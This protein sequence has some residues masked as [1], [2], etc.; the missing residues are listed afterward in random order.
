M[1][2][3]IT[4]IPQMPNIY[5]QSNQSLS[6]TESE[7]EN[8]APA[9]PTD[10]DDSIVLSDLVRTGE[11]SRLRRRGALRLDHGHTNQTTQQRSF[12]P[13]VI[14]VG[15]PSWDSESEDTQAGQGLSR[16]P[17][18]T[19]TRSQRSRRVGEEETKFSL[20]CGGEVS[21]LDEDFDDRPCTPFVPSPLPA[22]PASSSLTSRPYRKKKR[23]NGCGALLHMNATPRL[24]QGLWSAK[25]EASSAVI[26]MEPYYF[27]KESVAK[28]VRSACGCVR[29]GVGCTVW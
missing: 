13:S 14:V 10:A 6:D 19:R 28:I 22:Y 5:G 25:G 18:Y 4:V 27:D 1:R 8:I 21:D 16:V 11:A 20:F 17:R 26:N 3:L 15:S 7:L 24:R 29:E 9:A 12:S 23:T 2:S